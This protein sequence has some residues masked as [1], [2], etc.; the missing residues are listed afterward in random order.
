[1]KT[2]TPNRRPAARAA[3]T[4]IELLTGMTL[5]GVMTSL[6]T[7]TITST[8]RVNQTIHRQTTLQMDGR[9]AMDRMT[10]DIQSASAVVAEYRSRSGVYYRSNRTDT[11]VLKTPSYDSSNALTTGQDHIIYRLTAAATPEDGPYQLVRIVETDTDSA[12]WGH[13]AKTIA[14]NVKSA[15]FAYLVH[16]A[17]VS[18]GLEANLALDAG[19]LGTNAGV[20]QKVIVG[21]KPLLL[22][23]SGEANV[24]TSATSAALGTLVFVQPPQNNVVIDVVYAVAPWLLPQTVSVTEVEI[25]LTM[26]ANASPLDPTKFSTLHLDSSAVLRNRG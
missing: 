1:M 12:R 7:G 23:V 20:V 8:L 9:L 19:V 18:N 14:R 16:Q 25:G 22:G 5:V 26:E 11:L 17:T 13:R 4:L 6:L 21:G 15:A 3:F 24:V 2:R 10:Q